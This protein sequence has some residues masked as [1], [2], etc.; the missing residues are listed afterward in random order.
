MSSPENLTKGIGL[1]NVKKRLQL[2]YP[3]AHELIIKETSNQFE[4]ILKMELQKIPLK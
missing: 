4:V 3:N 1:E 2:L